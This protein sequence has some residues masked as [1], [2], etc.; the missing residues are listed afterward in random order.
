MEHCEQKTNRYRFT[1]F[2]FTCHIEMIGGVYVCVC[3]SVWSNIDC[4]FQFYRE[5]ESNNNWVIQK[6]VFWARTRFDSNSSELL[7]KLMQNSRFNIY[8]INTEKIKLSRN[9]HR[10]PHITITS[11]CW[12]LQPCAVFFLFDLLIQLERLSCAYVSVW[13]SRK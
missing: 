11:I 7:F 1:P 9:F 13:K 5:L 2:A 3:E 4:K 6:H 8:P 12:R 10:R